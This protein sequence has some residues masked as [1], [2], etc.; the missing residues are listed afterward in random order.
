MI[1]CL[2]AY[3]ETVGDTENKEC[4]DKIGPDID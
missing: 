2:L 1:L 4:L 3:R